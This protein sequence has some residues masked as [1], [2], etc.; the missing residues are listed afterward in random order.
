M[1]Y[2]SIEKEK[3]RVEYSQGSIPESVKNFMPDVYRDGDQFICILGIDSNAITGKGTTIEEA[4][5][6]W[7]R[8][9]Q[10]QKQ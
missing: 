2:K 3:I 4:L 6:D 1:K 10:E 9:F 7:D 5:K 8:A